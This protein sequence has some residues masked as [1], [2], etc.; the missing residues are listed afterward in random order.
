MNGLWFVFVGW[1]LNSAAD[2]SRYE[3]TLREHLTGVLVG[4]VMEKD[5]ESVRPDTNV[6]DVVQTFFIQKRKRA[7]PVTDGDN[8]V[9]L[10]TIS[11][12]K[13]FS[14]DKWQEYAGITGDAS[15]TNPCREAGRRLK[16][17]D[18]INCTI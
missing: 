7:I 13:G 8:L 3:A 10:V 12:V 6:A 18:E 16:Y 2:N 17:G 14:Q 15:R 4:Q 9:G 5:I 11:D 1:F